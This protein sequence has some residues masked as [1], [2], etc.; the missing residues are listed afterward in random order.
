MKSYILL[1]V[2]AFLIPIYAVSSPELTITL[3][4]ENT[5]LLTGEIDPANLDSTLA[6]L[7][8]KRLE[9]KD[10]IYVVVS[11]PG[12]LINGIKEFSYALSQ[13]EN[14]E[15]VVLQ[16]MS[17]AAAISQDF[18]GPVYGPKRLEFMLH[19]VATFLLP[20]FYKSYDLQRLI[21]GLKEI[22]EF[23]ETMYMH[24]NKIPLQLFRQRVEGKDWFI[25]AYEALRYKMVDAIVKVQCSPEMVDMQEKI[26]Y[27][28]IQGKKIIQPELCQALK[29]LN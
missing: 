7:Y 25:H 13:V 5:V 2:I 29:K 28:D 4:P 16:A 10:T 11:S 20:G 23:V 3:T 6:D 14:V 12:G 27:I 21:D 22:D 8:E 1:Y 9:H 26:M 18:E 15:L 19:R 24:R 17:A